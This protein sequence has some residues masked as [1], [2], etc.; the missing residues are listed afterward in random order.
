MNPQIEHVVT[1]LALLGQQEFREVH[2]SQ[3]AVM[4]QRY[5]DLADQA[6]GLINDPSNG[7]TQAAQRPGAPDVQVW[8]SGPKVG[9]WSAG[10]NPNKQSIIDLMEEGDYIQ[11]Y[12]AS[13]RPVAR[14]QMLDGGIS[15][16]ND[17]NAYLEAVRRSVAEQIYEDADL[18]FRGT[19]QAQSGWTTAGQEWSLS[20][21]VLPDDAGD[22]ADTVK[23]T[24]KV[25]F[26]PNSDQPAE[27]TFEGEDVSFDPAVYQL[28]V[29]G[30]KEA[31]TDLEPGF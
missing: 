7:L 20:A 25:L 19:V 2:S 16:I 30:P 15:W 12:D 27:V 11:G 5:Q 10:P 31:D 18:S 23:M 3:H 17:V 14:G 28:P 6:Q 9:M 22:G 4:L 1:E 26:Y 24:F 29:A 13:N 21:F 8:M